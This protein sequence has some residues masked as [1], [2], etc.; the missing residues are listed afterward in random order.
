M[1]VFCGDGPML[2]RLKYHANSSQVNKY[3]KF[4]GHIEHRDVHE[5]YK[6]SD[7]F[8]I[9]SLHEARALTLSEACYNGIAV[10]GSSIRTIT[11]IIR[12][13]DNGLIFKSE[14]IEDLS[15]KLK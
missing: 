14:N 15:L 1:L 10:I 8:V 6:L 13:G 3:I 9:P 4:Y 2:K 11:N 7:I 12:D 5:I